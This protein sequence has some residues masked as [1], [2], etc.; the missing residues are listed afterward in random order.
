MKRPATCLLLLVFCLVASAQ[1]APNEVTPTQ[2]S[3]YKLGIEMGRRNGGKRDDPKEKVEAFC[4]CVMRVLN[5]NMAESDWQRA[6]YYSRKRQDREEQQIL[7]P[8]MS[9]LQACRANAS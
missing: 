4:A 3:T 5:E 2:V 9:K 1:D 7:L 6:Y 8:H